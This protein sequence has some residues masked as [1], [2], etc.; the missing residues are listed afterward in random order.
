MGCAWL[1]CWWRRF[2]AGGA[3]AALAA[4]CENRF[5][6]PLLIST[7]L[8]SYPAM[9][10]ASYLV[11]FPLKDEGSS[12]PQSAQLPPGARLPELIGLGDCF[13]VLFRGVVVA[14]TVIDARTP[15]G[16]EAKVT[17]WS[18]R[19]AEYAGNR[20]AE[21]HSDAA[22]RFRGPRRGSPERSWR[23]TSR[24]GSS[25]GPSS[26]RSTRGSDCWRR[27]W[28]GRIRLGRWW[29]RVFFAALTSGGF[30]ME[31]ATQ[32]PRELTAILQAVLILFLAATSGLL[33]GKR[34]P[35]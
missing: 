30:A 1:W 26:R 24:S 7:L 27:C 20:P 18:P 10:L 23:W 17:G 12:L 3:Y 22:R 33:R 16:F 6:V 15:V 25:M 4:V 14:Y 34:S 8:L 13:Y 35:A 2:W 5:G 9:S 28:R 11:R 31:R 19:F 32:V 21:A 29:R